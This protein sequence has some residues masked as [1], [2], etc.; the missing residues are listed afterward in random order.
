[1]ERKTIEHPLSTCAKF[2]FLWVRD[3]RSMSTGLKVQKHILLAS[4]MLE[5]SSLEQG[6]FPI[7]ES[8]I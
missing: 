6:S 5:V 7:L 8:W 4:K 3:S 2:L 1:M